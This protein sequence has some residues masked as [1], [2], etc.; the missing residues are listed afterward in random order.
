[1]FFPPLLPHRQRFARLLL[2]AAAV[3]AL[4]TNAQALSEAQLLRTGQFAW[5]DGMASASTADADELSITVNIAK[6]RLYVYQAG[7]LIGISTVS[8]G[9]PGHSTPLGDFTVLQK[10]QWHRSNIYSNAPM[11]YMQRL[12]WTGIALHGGNLPGYPASHGCIRLPLAF[13]KQLFA[14]TTL[15]VPVTIVGKK[16]QPLVKLQFADI[17][18]MAG[19]E[20]V[21]FRPVSQ[22]ARGMPANLVPAVMTPAPIVDDRLLPPSRPSVAPH[23][24]APDAIDAVRRGKAPKLDFESLPE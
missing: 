9:K 4:P 22:P 5:A 17:E 16:N 2:F 14:I 18:W 7:Q 19:D 21:T 13:A 23:W 8:T 3:A 24:A 15:G 10:R 20:V 6:Q 1:M 12:T 11:P